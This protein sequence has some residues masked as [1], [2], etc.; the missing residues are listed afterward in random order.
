MQVKSDNKTIDISHIIVEVTKYD[1]VTYIDFGAY[2][3]TIRGKKYHPCMINS[4]G[5]LGLRIDSLHNY[6]ISLIK[7]P[8]NIFSK[9]KI[10]VVKSLTSLDFSLQEITPLIIRK[11]NHITNMEYDINSLNM[12]MK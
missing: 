1:N 7:I 6:T 5:K 8:D 11:I 2:A 9:V 3:K 4:F 10:K 12:E